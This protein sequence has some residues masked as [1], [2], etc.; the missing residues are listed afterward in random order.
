MNERDKTQGRRP[1]INAAVAALR[2]RH[3]PERMART[4]IGFYVQHYPRNLSA[5]LLAEDPESKALALWAR[6]EREAWPHFRPVR[7]VLGGST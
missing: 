5:D 3:V 6:P 1:W 7:F 4:V 2:K